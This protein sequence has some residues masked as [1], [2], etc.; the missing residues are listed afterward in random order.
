MHNTFN[1][2]FSILA[3]SAFL[4]ACG[5]GAQKETDVAD[6]VTFS[7]AEQQ[8]I[9]DMSQV[10]KDLP[11]PSIVP[12]TLMKLGTEYDPDLV[13]S[14][15]K[16]EEYQTNEDKAALNLG[17]YATDVGYQVAYQ[18]V[19]ESMSH[20][21]ALQQLA[22]TV[23]VSTA[24]DMSLMEQYEQSLDN[25]DSLSAL[26]NKT[27][28]LAEERLESSD[29]LSMA[30]LVLSGSF[31]EGLYLIIGIVNDYQGEGL[32]EQQRNEKLQPLVQLI[33]DQEKPLKDVIG[34]M[35]DIPSDDAILRM[36]SE[37]EILRILYDSDMKEIRE[38][39]GDDENFIISPD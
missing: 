1:K 14:I 19:Q 30:A 7:D 37:L 36:I 24:F 4:F 35:K 6:D 5:G 28:L 2:S 20:M 29:R 9:S 27:M 11:P 38:A 31:V 25:P 8:I 23:G 39:M 26:L 33:L 21:D 32:T 10:I 15:D 17:V 18:Q 13:N 12:N 16:I 3:V 22:E 34:L